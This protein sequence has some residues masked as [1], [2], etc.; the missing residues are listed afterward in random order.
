MF[1]GSLDLVTDSQGKGN[2]TFAGP[3]NPLGDNGSRA[4]FSATAT[5]PDS[6]TSSFSEPLVL[7]AAGAE[8]AQ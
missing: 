1:V 5:G 7:T 3:A 8:A 2:F 4:T 6:A